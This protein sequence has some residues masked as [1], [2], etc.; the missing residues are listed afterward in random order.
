MDKTVR[1]VSAP[2]TPPAGTVPRPGPPLRPRAARL[3]ARAGGRGGLPPALTA[4]AFTLAQLLV[5]PPGMGLGWDE[6][7]YVSQVSGHSPAAFFSAPR[8]RGVPLLVAPVAAWS[9]S[10]VL[11]RVWLAVLAGLGLFL[12]FHAWRGLFPPHVRAV[13]SGLFATLWITLFYG[14][15]AMPNYWVAIG[16]LACVG[17]VLRARADPDD[18][19]AVWGVAASAM[20]LA[21]MRPTDAVWVALPLLALLLCVRTPGRVR[22]CAALAAGLLPGAVEWAVEAYVDYGGLGARLDQAARIQ[23]GLGWNVAIGD[24]M[25]SLGG[26][27]LCRPCDTPMPAPAVLA[28]WCAL[29][30]AAALGLALAVRHRR[31]TPTLLPLVCA[32]TAALPYLF[33]IGYAAPRFLLPV[34]ALLALPVADVLVHAVT[35]RGR[36]WRPAAVTLV[37]LALA[38]HLAV[39]YTVLRGA[40]HRTTDSHRDWARGAAAL[41]RL[42]VRPP[43]ALSGYEAIPIAFYAGCSSLQT[44][45]HNTNA[46][47]AEIGRTAQLLPVAVLTEPGEAPPAYARTWRE[48]RVDGLSGRAYVAPTAAMAASAAR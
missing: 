7:V 47:E 44:T 10:T 15:Q 17:H 40:V 28:W 3:L 35:A 12:A 25:R 4:G 46:T 42:G 8:A 26:D 31:L 16:A 34:Y 13:A 19:V 23:G 36:P 37:V 20:L 11:L 6:T 29:P 41:H 18:R 30:V 1:G 33:M 32:A 9:S 39:Q 22:L 2:D 27:V 5:V 43:C 45:G 14:P 21:W 38:G 24:Q 48:R